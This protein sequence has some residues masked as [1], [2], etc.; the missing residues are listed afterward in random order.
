M[1][2]SSVHQAVKSVGTLECL[3]F[4]MLTSTLVE[5]S[6]QSLWGPGPY[7]GNYFSLIKQLRSEGQTLR[8]TQCTKFREKYSSLQSE[9]KFV[10]LP[11]IAEVAITL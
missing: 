3:E 2:D 5:E 7:F 9:V 6:C 10:D 4:A 1:R 11:T 8:E